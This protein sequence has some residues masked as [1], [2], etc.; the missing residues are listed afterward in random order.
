MRAIRLFFLI[1]LPLSA[2][3]R[4]LG[5]EVSADQ[6]ATIQFIESLRD[7]ETGAFKQTAKDKP[8][9]RATN[10]AVKALKAL[11]QKVTNIETIQK[12]VL[13]CYDAKTGAFAEPG[14]K[15]DATITSI[16]I[17]VACEVGIDKKEFPKAMEYLLANAKTFEEVR[18][19]AAAVEAW[20]RDGLKL[21]GI[22]AIAEKEFNSKIETLS[23]DTPFFAASIVTAKRLRAVDPA[24]DRVAASGL[25]FGQHKDGG[26]S[27]I[28]EKA[29]NIESTYRVMRAF[30]M[31]EA[32][33]LD[34][35]QLRKFLASHHN[36]DG[37]SAT[38]SGDLSTISGTYYMVIVSKWLDDMEK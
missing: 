20:G 21:E 1:L 36:K 22:T 25:V 26:W 9:L 6:K 38:K 35:P 15:P 14:G 2:S 23:K 32:K 5:G 19:G 30:K 27:K 31:L 29:S 33:P 16:G 8:S 11:D 13:G 24:T 18:I 34:I 28:D 12:F 10:G 17:I 3:E 37:G 7:K 4:G